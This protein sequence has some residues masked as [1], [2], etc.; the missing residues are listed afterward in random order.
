MGLQV[1]KFRDGMRRMF[2][3]PVA[4]EKWG[5]QASLQREKRYREDEIEISVDSREEVYWAAQD[6][7]S[8][9]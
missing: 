5:G 4:K 1:L 7:E 3:P 2:I 6:G 8:C 9:I